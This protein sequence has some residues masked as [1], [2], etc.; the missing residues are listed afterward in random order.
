MGLFNFLSKAQTKTVKQT[1][2]DSFYR[3]YP[4]TPYISD[5]RG[6]D[7]LERARLFP[8]QSI[9][10]KAMM[11]KYAEGL[12]P[13]HVYM[14]YWLKK[15]TNKKVPTYFEYKYGVDFKKEKAFLYENGFL[16]DQNKPTEKG[17]QMIKKY[18]DVIENHSAKK[19]ITVNDPVNGDD[20]D[21]AE[22]EAWLNFISRGGTSK[23]WEK[24]SDKEKRK[25]R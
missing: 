14:L 23:Q 2:I 10:P 21:D 11:T 7:W 1:I 17:E 16:D 12:L 13:G 6:E 5:D 18:N 8:A 24:L 15:Y 3:G 22:Y 25:Y 4:V 20:G 9:I 19:E